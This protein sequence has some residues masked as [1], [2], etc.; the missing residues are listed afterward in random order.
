MLSLYLK[1][2]SKWEN[3]SNI[4]L[5]PKEDKSELMDTSPEEDEEADEIEQQPQQI[6]ESAL[7]FLE[8]LINFSIKHTFSELEKELILLQNA[9]KSDYGTTEPGDARIAAD[10]T[11]PNDEE[12]IKEA[13]AKMSL[14]LMVA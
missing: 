7:S 8:A 3:V 1:Q 13:L 14:K 4:L 6:E 10:T 5:K 11:L 9:I 12:L 2:L